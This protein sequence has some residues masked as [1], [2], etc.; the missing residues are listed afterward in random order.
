MIPFASV[1]F[2]APRLPISSTTAR[3]GRSSAIRRPSSMVSSSECVSNTLMDGPRQIVQQIGRDEALLGQLL[4]S[5]FTA[6]SMQPHG[7][8]N[9]CLDVARKLR[10]QACDH[11]CKN[12][13]R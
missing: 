9:G 12:V 8:S 1:V 3:F 11:P 6:T 2:P 13:A 5:E 7:R 10:D 4:C